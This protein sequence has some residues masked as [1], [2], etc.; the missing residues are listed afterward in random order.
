[1]VGELKLLIPMAGLIDKNA[2]LARLT[3]EIEKLNKDIEHG[4]IKMSNA[5]YVERAPADI[6]EK[7]RQRINDMQSALE[8]LQEQS[9]KIEML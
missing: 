4:D 6:V 9:K 2:E 8:K 7:E 5:S 3:K 1:M